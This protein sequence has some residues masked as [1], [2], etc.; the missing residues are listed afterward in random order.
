M[1]DPCVHAG[2]ETE[3]ETRKDALGRNKLNNNWNLDK[4]E[5][6]LPANQSGRFHN[7]GIHHFTA[8]C[9]FPFFFFLNKLKDCSNPA[10]SKSVGTIFP[11]VFAHF[12]SI[13]FLVILTIF[14]FFSLLLYYF[15]YGDLWS[16]IFD[17]TIII[18]LRYHKLHPYKLVNLFDPSAT[19]TLISQH[20]L[21]SRQDP[22]PAKRLRLRW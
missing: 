4:A 5:N 22:P 17:V 15:C 10:W 12:L 11:T 3:L 8:L 18:I 20:L 14:Q 16:V 6:S 19:T 1:A 13:T 21:T 7:I 2:E 9:K